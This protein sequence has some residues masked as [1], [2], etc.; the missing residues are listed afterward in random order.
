MLQI[1]LPILKFWYENCYKERR[2]LEM[3]F[4]SAFSKSFLESDV[5][6][7]KDLAVGGK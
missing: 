1:F 3:L 5:I 2:Y 7:A 4:G 6:V